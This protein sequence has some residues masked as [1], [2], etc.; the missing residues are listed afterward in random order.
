MKEECARES[1]SAGSV[2]MIIGDARR[3]QAGNFTDD[4]IEACP[5]SGPVSRDF[6]MIINV[7]SEDNIHARTHLE[8][9]KPIPPLGL[10]GKVIALVD[11]DRGVVA[12]HEPP[13]LFYRRGMLIGH[14]RQ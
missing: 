1:G 5:A 13:P 3:G 12:A 10:E 11:A 8:I 14:K 7:L 4:Q 6:D 2:C 9:G